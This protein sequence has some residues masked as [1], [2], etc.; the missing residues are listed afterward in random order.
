LIDPARDAVSF[1][2]GRCARGTRRLAAAAGAL[3]PTSMMAILRDH[4]AAGEAAGWTPEQTEGRTICMHAAEG[5]RRS[6]SVGSMVGELDGA[7]SVHWVTGTSAPCLSLFKPVLLS[8]GLPDRGP[9][10]NDHFDSQSLWWRHER[11]HRAA[12]ADFAAALIAFAPE[13][14]RLETSFIERVD[15]VRRDGDTVAISSVIADCW[16]E[17]E[18]TEARWLGQA[19]RPAKSPGASAFRRSWA[20]L[21]H[22]AGLPRVVQA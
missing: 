8:A 20:R 16:R 13:R 18:E 5:A 10:P 9:R 17:A 2:R 3:G 6:Q 22:V 12:L 7:A 21:N 4:G 19:V 1:G 14:D 15:R 11:R